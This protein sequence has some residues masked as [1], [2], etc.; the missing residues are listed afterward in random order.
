MDEALCSACTAEDALP[1]PKPISQVAP[2]FEGVP[3]LWHGYL[4]RGI[5]TLLLGLWKSGK[6]TL[7]SHLLKVMATG[8][9]F[10]GFPVRQSR[11]LIISEELEAKWAERRDTLGLGD[12]VHLICRP[13]KA[14]P[15]LDEWQT[16]VTHIAE[17]VREN[18]YDLV[19]FDPIAE[20]WSVYDENDSGQVAG[21][22]IPLSAITEAG[23]GILLVHH[24]NKSDATEGRASRGSSAL[25]GRVDI[26]VEFRRY[27]PEHSS[28]KRTLRGY[29]RYSE[30]PTE[31]V[32]ELTDDG[33]KLVGTRGEVEADERREIILDLCDAPITLEELIENW[34]DGPVKPSRRTL[35]LSITHK[36]SK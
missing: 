2:D 34:P 20:L 3:W 32:V 11:V 21:A 25:P 14:R 22:L 26:I 36:S 8:G 4:G 13:W 35:E 23:A 31:V 16:F 15:K 5:Q 10:C 18:R 33:Y 12:H 9:A 19:V 6:T 27:D 24:P 28:R 30:T 1:V 17:L 29:S 7:I